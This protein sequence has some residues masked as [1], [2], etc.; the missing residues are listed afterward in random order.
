MEENPPSVEM[1]EIPV[2]PIEESEKKD[3]DAEVRPP[4]LER[5]R[6]LS[7]QP[8]TI[9]NPR[10]LR[11]V[12]QWDDEVDDDDDVESPRMSTFGS[13]A[14]PSDRRTSMPAVFDSETAVLSVLKNA[15]GKAEARLAAK[16]QARAEAREIRLR[17]LEKQ[18]KERK[19]K[20]NGE[21]D[22]G[23]P[24]TSTPTP[25][26]SA[27]ASDRGR[28]GGVSPAASSS[29]LRPTPSRRSSSSQDSSSNDDRDIPPNVKDLRGEVREVEEKFRKAMVS[30]A[31]LDNEKSALTYQVETLK[32]QLLDT[33]ETLANL[34]REHRTRCRELEQLKRVAGKLKEE[35]QLLRKELEERERLTSELGLVMVYTEEMGEDGRPKRALISQEAIQVLEDT[36]EGPL[37]VRIKKFA[38]ERNE[39]ED[40]L[41]RLR[42]ELEEERTKNAKF[43]KLMSSTP[44]M[45]GPGGPTSTDEWIDA[46]KEN[47]RLVAEYKVRVQRSEQEIA[48]LQ[49]NVAR[50]DSQAQRYKS[51][52]DTAERN[53]EELKLE[54]RKLLREVSSGSVPL[55]LSPSLALSF[56]LLFHHRIDSYRLVVLSRL[57]LQLRE[58]QS[59]VDDLETSRTFLQRQCERLKRKPYAPLYLTLPLLV[60]CLPPTTSPIFVPL[61]LDTL[62]EAQTK[63][64]EYETANLHLQKRLDKL[65]NAR[66]TLLKE[67][68][69]TPEDG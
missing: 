59:K 46:Q 35:N 53:E 9:V 43:C 13:D 19:E 11:S 15:R 26:S 38:E 50:L 30:N 16:R 8:G 29:V 42:I 1:P 6:A 49:A 40:E 65:K 22:S 17:E 62:R 41:R 20:E 52:A 67:L 61:L 33:Q 68:S 44:Q 31:Q 60:I 21:E 2:V 28:G 34:Q 58:L 69:S 57:S 64:E 24:T 3:S 51:A 18:R 48:T 12:T 32:D 47:T 10:F 27:S 55:L 5:C 23:A 7:A 56:S 4:P 25:P 36:G 37:D 54:K 66:S 39:M 63:L 45:N 14:D